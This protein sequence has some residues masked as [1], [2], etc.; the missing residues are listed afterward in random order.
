MRALLAGARRKET[1]L[2]ALAEKL[3][4]AESPSDTKSAVDACGQLAIVHARSLGGRVKVHKQRAHGDIL[5]LRFGPK[6][7]SPEGRTLL[8]GH[9]D[10]VWPIGAIQSMPCKIAPDPTGQARLWGPGTLDMKV[11]VAMAFTAIEMLIEADLLGRNRDREIILL[12]NTDEEIGSPV[13]RPITEKL[14]SESSAVYVLEPAQNLDG[15]QA[16]YKTAR[17]G[18]GNWRIEVTGIAAHAG[19]DF[20]KGA[21]AL[22]ELARVIQTVSAWTELD[23]GLT[24]SVNVA[25]AGGK[26]NVIPAAAWAEVD[27]RLARKADGPR[28]ARKFASLKTSFK[29]IDKRCKLAITGGVNRPPMERTRGTIALYKQA[30]ALAADLGF[31]LEEAAT[32]GASDGNFTSAV[33]ISTLDGMGAVGEGAHASH[34]SVL[35]AHLAPRTALLAGM[36][37]WSGK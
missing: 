7:K 6:S 21:N 37:T 32:G 9:I 33:G 4:R 34:E 15:Q 1:Q 20:E 28:I 13:S 18:T 29:T 23:R 27:V 14:A 26:T 31:A 24:V 35:I 10:T 36:L 12:L 19:V 5:E 17:K 22:V 25:G 16:A 2:L 3:V 8:L 11:G 30:R